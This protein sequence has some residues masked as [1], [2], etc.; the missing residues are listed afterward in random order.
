MLVISVPKRTKGK[1]SGRLSKASLYSSY[2]GYFGPLVKATVS[3]LAVPSGHL[4]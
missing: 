4:R 3:S 1:L 2:Y